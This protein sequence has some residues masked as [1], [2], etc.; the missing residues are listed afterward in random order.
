[1]QET[2]FSKALTLGESLCKMGKHIESQRSK[3]KLPWHPKAKQPKKSW[4]NILAKSIST[5]R[6]P[7]VMKGDDSSLGDNQHK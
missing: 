7:W 3:H 6:Q 5:R 2:P 1:M 4:G